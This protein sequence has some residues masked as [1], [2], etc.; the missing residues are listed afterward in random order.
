MVGNMGDGITTYF[1]NPFVPD[2][3]RRTWWLNETYHLRTAEGGPRHRWWNRIDPGNYG[4]N[5]DRFTRAVLAANAREFGDDVGADALVESLAHRI[6]EQD[7]ARRYRGLSMWG[8]LYLALTQFGHEDAFRGLVVDGFPEAWRTGP[9]LAEAAYPEVLVAYAV[10]D[11]QAL[12]LVL[13]PGDG[14]VR[15]RLGLERLRPGREYAVSGGV[16]PTVVSDAEGRALL[17]VD[18]ADRLEVRVS[19]VG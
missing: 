1:L 5:T 18:L 12:D 15:T 10:T 13:R 14:P 6:V 17:E 16:A 2:I 8:N 19:P 7:G 4:I 3:A 11:G 9:R